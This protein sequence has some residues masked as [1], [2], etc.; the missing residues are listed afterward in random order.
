MGV[1]NKT[2][3]L[4]V[5]IEMFIGLFLLTLSGLHALQS[6]IRRMT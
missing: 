1:V 6:R 5:V 4:K 3:L 2:L